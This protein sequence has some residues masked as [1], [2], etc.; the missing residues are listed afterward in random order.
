M[1]S[2]NIVW[3]ILAI[4]GL[5]IGYERYAQGDRD[6]VRSEHFEITN[7]GEQC[8]KLIMEPGTHEGKGRSV[9]VSGFSFKDTW[10]EHASALRL[11]KSFTFP[12]ELTGEIQVHIHY[13]PPNTTPSGDTAC[14]DQAK[15]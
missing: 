14:Q 13:I 7:T 10:M 4:A 12:R 5:V 11:A 1:L 3:I 9:H 6:I 15:N 8:F 2:R